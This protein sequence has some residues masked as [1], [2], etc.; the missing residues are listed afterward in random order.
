MSSTNDRPVVV[1]VLGGPGAGKGTQC[2][3]IVNEF[4]FV[5]L[6]AG[7]LLRKEQNTPGSEYSELIDNHIRNGS[8]VPVDITC[9]LLLNKMQSN[10]REKHFLIDGF[11]R[12]ED[13]LLGWQ[14]IVGDKVI[15]KGVLFFECGQET[16]IARCLER[17]K[18]GSRTDDNRNSLIKRIDTYTQSTLPIVMHYDKMNLLT[19]INADR[20]IGK[21]WTDVK[22]LDIWKM[23]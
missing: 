11:P 17:G 4:G 19:K 3:K 6:S 18:D 7:E 12:N 20:S 8:I 23:T 10:E 13:N 16:C 22:S 15:V 2:A 21:I 1:F 9:S 5:H 14:R